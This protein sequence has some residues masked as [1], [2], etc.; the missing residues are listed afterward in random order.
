MSIAISFP[1]RAVIVDQPRQCNS[2]TSAPS[3]CGTW[4]QEGHEVWAISALSP[5][6]SISIIT[7]LH[8]T[9]SW[10]TY[11]SVKPRRTH[12]RIASQFRR[13]LW[14]LV[15]CSALPGMPLWLK[16][17]LTF[18]YSQMGRPTFK[19]DIYSFLCGAD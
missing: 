12:R 10:A 4:G 13:K 18:R 8:C 3:R 1:T 2:H 6:I 9:L 14:A 7:L 19:S 17:I 15:I 16:C 5:T 11:G